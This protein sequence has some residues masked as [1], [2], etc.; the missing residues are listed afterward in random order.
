IARLGEL[1]A[2]IVEVEIPN[3]ELS[4]LVEFP[5]VMAEAT[6]YHEHLLRTR[7][8]KYAPDIRMLLE[9]GEAISGPKYLKA[10]RVRTLIKQSFRAALEQ[11][12]VLATPTVPHPPLPIGQ[13]T[14]T[15][16]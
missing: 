6:S 9:A 8:D 7:A 4:I 2:E 11:C 13:E 15:I 10:Q 12:D 14:V 1:G 5:I 16:D 3:V